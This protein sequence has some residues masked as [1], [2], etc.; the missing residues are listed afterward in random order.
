MN[1]RN[2]YEVSLI[3]RLQFPLMSNSALS[4]SLSL[5]ERTPFQLLKQ[6]K[7]GKYV[8]LLDVATF[9]LGNPYA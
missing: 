3:L 7:F 2:I 9:V 5:S 6:L 1:T 4:L 8:E